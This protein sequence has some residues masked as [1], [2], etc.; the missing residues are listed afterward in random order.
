MVQLSLEYRS[1]VAKF[2]HGTSCREDYTKINVRL[3]EELHPSCIFVLIGIIMV[4]GTSI[5]YVSLIIPF[6]G[7]SSVVIAL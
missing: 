3:R 2:G 7:I 1:L 6:R 4:S 5:S